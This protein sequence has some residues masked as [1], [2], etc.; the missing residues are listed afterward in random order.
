[1]RVSGSLPRNGRNNMYH[2]LFHISEEAGIVKF[3]PRP[4]P[5]FFPAITGDV[6]Y[7]ITGK[8]LHNYLLPRDCPRVTYYANPDSK[9]ED[10]GRFLGQSNATFVVAIEAGWFQRVKESVLYSYEFPVGSFIPLDEIAGYF[11]SYESVVPLAE[12][13]IDDIFGEL[14][15]RGDIELRVLPELWTLG[16]AVVQSSLSYSLIR[17]R[18]ALTPAPPDPHSRP[19]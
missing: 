4:S 15:S 16:N 6:V 7:A 17:M 12:R 5:S 19:A 2:R 1:M 10:I 18:N 3:V 13:R 14:L 8:L 9:P 11:I